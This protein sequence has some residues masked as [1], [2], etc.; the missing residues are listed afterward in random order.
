MRTLNIESVSDMLRFALELAVRE[1][2]RKAGIVKI[3]GAGIF[4][5]RWPV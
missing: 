1:A 2:Y 4:K 5:K 3:G